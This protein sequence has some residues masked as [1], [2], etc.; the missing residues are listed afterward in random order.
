MSCRL[1]S[2]GPRAPPST[3]GATTVPT[4]T[5]ASRKGGPVPLGMVVT[6]VGRVANGPRHR[7]TRDRRR[8]A[9]QRISAVLD[10]EESAT[11]GPAACLLRG[12]SADP[13]DGARQSALG[14][15]SDPWR[16][17]EAWDAGL[18]GDGGEVHGAPGYSHRRGPG[19]P[20]SPITSSRSRPP[21][22]RERPPFFGSIGE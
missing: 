18:L 16:A 21:I 7:A 5:A 1:P 19:A 4:A 12:A 3:A 17:P 9:S 14:R 22:L 15:A 8:L 2:R 10:V 6:R 13:K 11:H 20:S